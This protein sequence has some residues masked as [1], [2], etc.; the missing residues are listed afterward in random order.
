MPVAFS[1]RLFE[2]IFWF[3]RSNTLILGVGH[4]SPFNGIRNVPLCMI[5]RFK[6]GLIV[7]GSIARLST[8]ALKKHIYR[9][10]GLKATL[11]TKE[12]IEAHERLIEMYE[13]QQP[14]Q[15]DIIGMKGV[16]RTKLPSSGTLTHGERI[17]TTSG[18]CSHYP[19]GGVM[20]PSSILTGLLQ[21]C[22]EC[23][24]SGPPIPRADAW[25][26]SLLRAHFDM[27]KL[28]STPVLP[29]STLVKAEEARKK[30]KPSH[31]FDANYR[32]SA[33]SASQIS[34]KLYETEDKFWK[35]HHTSFTVPGRQ[36][37]SAPA[38]IC[39]AYSSSSMAVSEYSVLP[40]SSRRFLPR[41]T[42]TTRSEWPTNQK[43]GVY[44]ASFIERKESFRRSLLTSSLA[45]HHHTSFTVPAPA[46]YASVHLVGYSAPAKLP[47][48]QLDL[49]VQ[50]AVNS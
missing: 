20:F 36:G 24:H 10:M 23:K 8:I 43:R 18:I 46:H 41:S 40:A 35:H 17:G 49:D 42:A 25:D 33:A 11:D 34:F 37:A 30:I 38:W 48:P 14:C 9:G 26:H 27:T 31:S 2:R 28:P 21:N 13:A 12:A 50:A 1:I 45:K 39:I 6:Y 47:F 4:Y 32:L 5:Q 15:L 16:G 44:T 19:N 7:A 22:R 3:I 29:P